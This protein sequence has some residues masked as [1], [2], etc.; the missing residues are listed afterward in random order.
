MKLKMM[1]HKIKCIENLQIGFPLKPGLYA[2]TGL[3]GS[4]KSTIVT[5]ASSVFFNM[6]MN[7]YFGETDDDAFIAFELDDSKREWRKDNG[8]WKS[9]F[10][11][12]MKI[13]GFYEGS[14]IF[15]N[16]FKDT[17]YDKLKNIERID[18][19]ELEHADDFIRTNLGIILQGDPNYYEK[20]WFVPKKH[21]EFN[22]FVFYYEKNSKRIS[23][24]HM[25]TGEN[26][27]LSILNSL[28]L[29]IKSKK[30]QQIPCVIF[31]DEIELAL[32]PASL[33][34]LV[35][36]LSEISI[37]NHYAIYFSTHSIELIGNI[38]PDNIYFIERHSDNSV[39]V[40]NPCYPAYATRTLYDHSGYDNVI[41]VEDD[42]A[43]EIIRQI[44]K[45]EKLL[46][47]RL[48]H[49]LPCG[50]Y[51]NVIDL[52]H[53]VVENNLLAKTASICIILDAD[54][55]SKVESYILRN[56]ISNNIPL[57]YL[58]IDSL[59]KYLRKNLFS[60]VDHNLFRILEDYVFHQRSLLD[61][62][63]DYRKDSHSKDDTNGKLLY[64][65][66]D[67]ELRNRHKSRNEL[68]EMIVEYLFD[69]DK[70]RINKTVEFLK[71]QFKH[72]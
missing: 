4:G 10:E 53:D 36:F 67:T 62:I 3:N 21:S 47:A 49:V 51:T 42:L 17:S 45:K 28:Y 18:V 27:L 30:D 58:P 48:V 70:E 61:I 14:L 6:P 15:G 23:Q 20:L 32:H 31:L 38:L 1:I 46:S 66:I 5:C 43:R 11:G 12:K 59:E 24:F 33:K 64:N 8:K 40:I 35:Y 44:L 71:K 72:S 16:R 57:N 69:N 19:N 52:A 39:E 68:I 29:R 41:L 50:G 26:L 13:K 22:G 37:Q 65:Y 34:R 2:I 56:G 60:D 9:K 25:S 7:D 63:A 55:K 54:V